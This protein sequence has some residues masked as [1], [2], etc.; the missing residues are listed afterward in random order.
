MTGEAHA[1]PSE[2]IQIWRR[3]FAP[4]IG[5]KHMTVETVEKND[6]RVFRRGV[7]RRH[8]RHA[9]LVSANA[10][11]RQPNAVSG[12]GPPIMRSVRSATTL[13]PSFS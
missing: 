8:A 2:P 12:T 10:K 13:P 5:A 4:A 6:D 3:E 1:P 9:W 7:V 11:V